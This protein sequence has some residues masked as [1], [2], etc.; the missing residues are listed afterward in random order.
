MRS[1]R[2][3]LGEAVGDDQRRAAVAGRASAA[4]SSAWAPALPASASASS[5]IASGG[6]G[7][8]KA[9]ERELLRLRRGQ[10]AAALADARSPAARAPQRS[11]APLQGVL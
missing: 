8:D 6:S 10:P 4:R 3:G 5:R 2:G 7:E 11:P 1:A 9:G